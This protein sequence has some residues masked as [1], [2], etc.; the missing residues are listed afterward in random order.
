MHFDSLISKSFSLSSLF[1]LL[2]FF[3]YFGF[4]FC[5]LFGRV[6]RRII[7]MA[8]RLREAEGHVVHE[9]AEALE[10]ATASERIEARTARV[11]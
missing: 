2:F 7:E 8:E 5:Y 3:F 4:S 11:R 10:E 9:G 6:E 1:T